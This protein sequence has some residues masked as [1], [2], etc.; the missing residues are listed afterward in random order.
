MDVKIYAKCKINAFAEVE[1]LKQD[2]SPFPCHKQTKHCGGR[3]R[4]IQKKVDG[5]NNPKRQSRR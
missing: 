4:Q 2:H 5:R 1:N 3:Q